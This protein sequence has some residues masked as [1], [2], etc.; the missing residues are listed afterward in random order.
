MYR[1]IHK[2]LIKFIKNYI[3][4]INL[5]HMQIITNLIFSYA[6][7]FNKIKKINQMKYIYNIQIQIDQ[8]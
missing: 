5:E 8:T 3:Y 7:I 2:H 1:K 6:I 4:I